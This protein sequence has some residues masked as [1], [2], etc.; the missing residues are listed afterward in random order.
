MME[1]FDLEDSGFL[2]GPFTEDNAEAIGTFDKANGYV[3]AIC[4]IGEISYIVSSTTGMGSVD[5]VVSYLVAIAAKYF[6]TYPGGLWAF[7][8]NNQGASSTTGKQAAEIQIPPSD[9]PPFP[10]PFASVQSC[11]NRKG[12]GQMDGN[13][14]AK[15]RNVV[16]VL[17]ESPQVAQW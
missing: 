9:W 4:D 8:F 14:A 13:N 15:S 5:A 3:G 16:L 6:K 10:R 7:S 2:D 12:G 17:L 1:F 11:H